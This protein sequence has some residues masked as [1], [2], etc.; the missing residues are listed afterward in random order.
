[1]TEAEQITSC[2][3]CAQG[4][5]SECLDPL[6]T[7]EG[8]IIPCAQRYRPVGDDSGRNGGALDPSQITDTKSTGRKRAAMLA[9]IMS[10]ML[11]EWAGL[12][13][14]GGGVIPIVGCAGNQLS[15]KK[16]G[17]PDKGWLPGHRHHGPD[18]AVINNA[19]G[20][21]LHRVCAIC[22][23]RWHALN[24]PS[25]GERGEA[26]EQFLPLKAYYLHDPNTEAT[27]EEQELVEAWWASKKDKRGDYPL[28]PEGLRKIVP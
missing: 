11:C 6:E 27:V 1:M 2:Y 22:H 10:G 12:R 3:P 18:K 26:H 16:Q 8:L 25:Y 4:L 15:D 21:N 14:A 24:D 20:S 23:N 13:Q 19:V 9:P 28:E 17:D 5:Y 7:P